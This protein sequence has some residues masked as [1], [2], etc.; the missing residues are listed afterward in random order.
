MYEYGV[1]R[2]ESDP[3]VKFHPFLLVPYSDSGLSME[4]TQECNEYNRPF[5]GK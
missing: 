2:A 1:S 5:H 4:T 3:R